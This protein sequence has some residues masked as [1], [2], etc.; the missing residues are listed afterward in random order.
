MKAKEVPQDDSILGE[1]RKATY[2]VDEQGHYVIV[3]TKGWE[4][5]NIVNGLAIGEVRAQIEAVR[6]Q[7]LRGEASALAFHM[8][9]CQ[10]TPALLAANVGLWRWQVQ[11]HLKPAVFARLDVALLAR[12]AAALG[13]SVAALKEVPR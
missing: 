2:A 10:M 11:R 12:Y 13:M 4:V 9:R 5:E 1:H 7:A 8:T 6:Q 3:P